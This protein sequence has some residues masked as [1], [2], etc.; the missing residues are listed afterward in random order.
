[1]AADLGAELFVVDDG[2]FVGRHDDTGGLGDWTPDPAKFPQGFGSFVDDVRA[3]GLEFGLWVEPESI[4]PKSRLYAEHPEWVYHLDGRE[5]TLI[6]NQLLLDLGREDVYRFVLSTLDGLLAE[7]P[8]RYLKWD[9]NRPPTERG[10]PG[11]G[12][13]ES[14]D[15]DGAHARNYLRVL[16]QPAGRA[17]RCGHRGLRRR[18][19][20]GRAG[21]HRPH[22]CRVAQR[23]HRA[24]GPT[25]H[26]S[27][28]SCTPT[29]RT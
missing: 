7:H 10:R 11:A 21:D 23:Q 27:T 26:F 9:M 20:P 4:S 2:W 18:R 14:L 15:L 12:A 13:P 16:D 3:L 17:P 25:V 6:R 22:R 29:P 28:V 5:P 8:I 19:G 24:A 1:V